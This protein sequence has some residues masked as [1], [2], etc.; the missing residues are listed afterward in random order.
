MSTGHEHSPFYGFVV[1][2]VLAILLEPDRLRAPPDAN[3][4]SASPERGQPDAA[5][6]S[7]LIAVATS[8]EAAT[9]T[10]WWVSI[11]DI[12]RSSKEVRHSSLP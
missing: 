1:M 9:T 8:G 11:S 12:T 6:P 10:T 3:G 2:A 7:S 5:G 4:T